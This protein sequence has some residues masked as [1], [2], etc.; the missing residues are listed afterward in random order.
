[1]NAFAYVAEK[2]F[3]SEEWVTGHAIIVEDGVVKCLIPTKELPADIEKKYWSEAFIAPA[4]IDLQIYGANKKLLAVHP[5]SDALQDLYQYCKDGG[6]TLCLP[7]L[8]TNSNNVFI[9][10]IDAV[11]QYRIKGGKGILGLHLEGPWINKKKKGAHVE[12]F[13]HSPTVKEVEELLDY[14]EGVIKMITLAPE[15]CSK[16]VVE[17][18]Q[19]RNIIISAGHSDATFEQAV[20]SF[21]SGVT[22]VTHLYNA[23]SPFQH[24]EPGLVGACFHHKRIRASII[25]D[26][27]HVAYEAIGIA[28]NIMK[29]RLFAITDAVTETT[30]GPYQHKLDGDRYTC[31]G[32]LSGSALTMHKA[33]VNLVQH[34]GIEIEEALRMCSTYPAEVI[35]INDTNGKIAPGYAAQ[36]VVINKQLKLVEVI[37]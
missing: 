13:I 17:F 11:K 21:H 24:R 15:V 14:G 31:N 23:M 6:A 5:G 34:A 2:I 37:T 36:F 12:Q 1:M 29:E 20:E 19:S 9:S 22:A 8:A 25:A 26:G 32:T 10:D 30:E 18:I 35:R 4:F 27:Y 33:F 16:E 3:T 7:T 28:K